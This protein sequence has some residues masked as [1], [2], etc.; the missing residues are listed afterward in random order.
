MPGELG[1]AGKAGPDGAAPE[2][3]AHRDVVLAGR[4]QAAVA[5]LNPRLTVETR[6][7]VFRRLIS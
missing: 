5:R 4:A 2:R 6:N 3:R 1:V 7:A